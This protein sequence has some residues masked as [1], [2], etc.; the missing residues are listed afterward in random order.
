MSTYLDELNSIHSESIYP[1][2]TPSGLAEIRL[3]VACATVDAL[4]DENAT[5]CSRLAALE[6]DGERLDWLQENPPH[7][8]W[9]V[10]GNHPEAPNGPFAVATGPGAVVYAETIRAAID[11]AQQADAATGKTEGGK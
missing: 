4:R 5:L 3:K 6:R 9:S 1:C 10:N 7:I 8:Y 2:A 11:A